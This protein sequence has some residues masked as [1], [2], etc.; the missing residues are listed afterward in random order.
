MGNAGRWVKGL[1]A[2]LGAWCGLTA[3]SPTYNWRDAQAEDAPLRALMPCKPERAERDVPLLGPERPTVK[4]RMMSCAVDDDTFAVA[5]ADL[6]SEA[7][8]QEASVQWTRAM[9]AGLGQ[10]VA[11]GQDAPVGWRSAARPIGGG[12]A[13][14]WT[15]PALNPAGRSLQAQVWLAARGRWLAQVA[16]YGP[17]AKP[18]VD[19]AF[20]GGWRFEGP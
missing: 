6:P 18:D 20:F 15:G 16:W 2:G 7:L 5:V 11:V 13:Q 19:D 10:T 14:V 12:V 9:W 1:A 17:N 3:C 4:L 8:A